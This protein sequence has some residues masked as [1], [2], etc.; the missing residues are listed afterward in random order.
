M[1]GLWRSVG[2]DVVWV[3]GVGDWSGGDGRAAVLRVLGGVL[4]GEDGVGVTFT[5]EQYRD[6]V[7]RLLHVVSD[8]IVARAHGWSGVSRVPAP[9]GGAFVEV[10]M[11]V[12]DEEVRAGIPPA[13]NSEVSR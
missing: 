9:N 11:F 2:G 6:A 5:D 4:P 13:E 10:T 12:T 8:K 7:N 3:T 1:R